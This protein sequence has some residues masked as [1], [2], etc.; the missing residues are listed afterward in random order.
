M[1]TL[2]FWNSAGEREQ[3]DSH[4]TL[5]AAQAAQAQMQAEWGDDD[6]C[7]EIVVN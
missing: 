3:H 7:F 4:P 5:A 1:Y 2:Y 6:S